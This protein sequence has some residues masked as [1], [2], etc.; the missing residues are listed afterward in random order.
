MSADRVDAAI[1]AARGEAPKPEMVQIPMTLGTGRPFVV[2][3]PRDFTDMEALQAV[4]GLLMAMDRI[5]Q[6]A[7]A[8]RLV[9]VRGGKPS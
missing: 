6:M 4:Q 8:S 3:L 2:A 9:D 1:A 5:R 7:P